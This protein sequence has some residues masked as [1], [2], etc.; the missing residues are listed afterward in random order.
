M[1]HRMRGSREELAEW[2]REGVSVRVIAN[3]NDHNYRVGDTYVIAHLDRSDGVFRA[4][5]PQ[6]GTLGNFLRPEDVQRVSMLGWDWLKRQIPRADVVLLEAFDGLAQLEMK[7]DVKVAIVSR[8]EDLRE[9]IVRV[10]SAES[11]RAPRAEGEDR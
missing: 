4:R 5:D 9:Q 8:L 11:A 3:T 10:A 7:E 2:I 6:D 1:R